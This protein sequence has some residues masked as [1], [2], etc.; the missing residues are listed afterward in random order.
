MMHIGAEARQIGDG[1]ALSSTSFG[2]RTIDNGPAKID[3]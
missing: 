2:L 1:M 3:Q